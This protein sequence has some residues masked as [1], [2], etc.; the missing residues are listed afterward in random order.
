MVLSC[1][2]EARLILRLEKEMRRT[3]DVIDKWDFIVENTPDLDPRLK[4]ML[5][6]LMTEMSYYATPA[7]KGELE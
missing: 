4:Q 7:E 1:G 2:Q 5:G 3:M 6:D